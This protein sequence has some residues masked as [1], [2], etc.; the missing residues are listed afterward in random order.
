MTVLILHV[1]SD[2]RCSDCG[3]IRWIDK[4]T[5][6]C[7]Y[8][9]GQALE[10]QDRRNSLTFSQKVARGAAKILCASVLI[11]VCGW[12][13]ITMLFCFGAQP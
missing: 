7:L 5:Q 12:A 13:L 10:V 3:R 6:R 4:K 8:C 2:L 11:G 9:L 1:Q